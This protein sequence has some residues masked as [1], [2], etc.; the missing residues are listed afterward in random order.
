MQRTST[1]IIAEMA[2]SHDGS[3]DL[4]KTI[5]DAAGKSGANAIQFQVWKK[6][7]IATPDHPDLEVL[8]SVELAYDTWHSLYS[9]V[10]TNYPGL[11]II[12]CIYEEESLNFCANMGVDSFKIHAADITNLPLLEKVGKKA[13]RT[14]LSV[15]ACTLDEIM[16]AAE[17]LTSNDC[18]DIWLMYG[19]QNFPTPMEDIDLTLMKHLQDITGFKV[20]Y[21]DHC[22]PEDLCAYSASAAARGL[23]IGVLEKHIT[24]DRSKKGADHQAALNPDEF[25]LFV[26]MMRDLDKSMAGGT[27]KPLTEAEKKYRTYSRKSLVAVRPI[28]KGGPLQA[29]DFKVLRAP[30]QGADPLVQR[31]LIGKL[32]KHDIAIGDI[33]QEN[34]FN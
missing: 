30:K 34:D 32:A 31:G 15:G 17:A 27:L 10:R 20:G 18:P 6:E 11:D 22:P 29:E 13:K 12:A 16:T 24:H 26:K 14:D 25:A 3:E 7:E 21:Q 33:L 28:K 2:C 23:G 8:K 19:L 4:A 1:Y 9:Y 5:I